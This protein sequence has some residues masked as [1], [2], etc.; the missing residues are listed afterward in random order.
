MAEGGGVGWCEMGWGGVDPPTPPCQKCQKWLV[1]WSEGRRRYKRD[2][3]WRRAGAGDTCTCE[4]GGGYRQWPDDGAG[5]NRRR[6]YVARR[7]RGGDTRRESENGGR[8]TLVA[9]KVCEKHGKGEVVARRQSEAV[10][11]V[12]GRDG[13]VSVRGRWVTCFVWA[14]VAMRSVTCLGGHVLAGAAD[15]PGGGV[16]RD[17]S[18]GRD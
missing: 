15:F 17:R 12:L 16:I 2:C 13:V 5:Q 11:P 10:V 4:G 6:R 3:T 14:E 1:M 7:G 18:L 9:R 8:A